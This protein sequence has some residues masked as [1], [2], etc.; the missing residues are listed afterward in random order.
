[1]NDDVLRLDSLAL[2]SGWSAGGLAKLSSL[3]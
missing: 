1:M 2:G 3:S